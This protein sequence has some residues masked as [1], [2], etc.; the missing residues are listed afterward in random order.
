MLYRFRHKNV[1]PIVIAWWLLTVASVVM[2]A[3][4]WNRLSR[5]V[6][7]SA[8]ATRLGESLNQ[9]FS[10]LQDAETGQ[11]GFLLT[12][13]D[14]YLE[15]FTN[16]EVSLSRGFN[17]LAEIAMRDR[18]LQHDL[19]DL[20]G[21]TELKMAEIRESIKIRREQDLAAS[22]IFVNSG[23]GK[24]TMDQVRKILA[25]MRQEQLDIYL[26]AGEATRRQMDLAQS[27]TMVAGLF[28]IGA[29]LCALYLVRVSYLQEK[30]QRELLEEKLRADK[31][32]VEKSAFLANMSHEIRTP[33][34]AILG[35]GELLATEPI[36]P[37]QA[38][39]V[40]SIRQSGTSLLQ[41][42]NDVLDLSK[43]EAGKLDLHLEPADVREIC[44]LLHTIFAQQAAMKSLRLEFKAALVPHALLL[45]RLR[46]RQVLVNLVGNAVKF[47]EQGYVRLQMSWQPQADDRSRGT[48]LIDVEDSGVGISPEKQQEI[49]KPF[50]QSDPR[51]NGEKEGTG[52][53]LNIVQRLT[54][55]MDG[56]VTLE[57]TLGQGSAFHLRFTNITVSARLPVSGDVE[58]DSATDFN[59]FVPATLLVV[60]DNETNRNLITSMFERTH[61]RIRL[62]RNGRETLESIA[63]MRPDLV[64]LDLRMPMMD[65]RTTLVEIRKLP[66]LELLPV[67]A[68][69]AS[70]QADDE[71]DLRHR[72]SGYLRKPFSR[73]ALYDELAQF[74]PRTSKKHDS[75]SASPS[76]AA[77]PRLL[78]AGK[79][80]DEWAAL[81]A[82]LRILQA[83][84]WAALRESLAINE[85]QAFAGKLRALAQ[86]VQCG[87][88]K[89]YA[90]TLAARAEAYAVR[91][92]EQHLSE[93][94]LLIHTLDQL[95][96]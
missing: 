19:L 30:S 91:D 81:T 61:H 84:E 71:R 96:K 67:I 18:I 52:L 49:F 42:I 56:T 79:G 40:R 46:L 65:G 86:T 27:L 20:R 74:L 87:P 8:E 80:A 76:G 82:E 10:A 11:Q 54:E 41:L 21:L 88:L 16:A 32:V 28:G 34:T 45:D 55:M 23:N 22:V 63:E 93:F 12:G 89:T 44:G 25:R 95:P 37:R 43:I 50:V 72:F 14:A 58:V 7:S 62:A 57:S 73:K 2:S 13:N 35:F 64:L 9:V 83:G 90:E 78:P 31:I 15:P 94:P 51:R 68:A 17:V 38:H 85:T 33:M 53:G 29:G 47:T 6:N 26:G 77:W 5:S 48:L 66:G 1:G 36:S 92:L 59:V 70:N 39:Y 69:T 75:P 60:D 3:L 4:V 24:A